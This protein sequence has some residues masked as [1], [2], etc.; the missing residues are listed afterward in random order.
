[1]EYWSRLGFEELGRK[2]TAQVAQEGEAGLLSRAAVERLQ[3]Y[4]E[5][6]GDVRLM[7]RA[8]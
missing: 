5:A 3:S 6:L 2:S 7:R 4:P 1:M 8:R